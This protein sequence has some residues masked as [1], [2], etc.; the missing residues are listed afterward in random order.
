MIGAMPNLEIL[1]I[2]QHSGNGDSFWTPSVDTN[3][4]QLLSPP[5]LHTL[6]LLDTWTFASP[7]LT[8]LSYLLPWS[9]S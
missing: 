9:L 2:Y 7:Q 5:F 3:I 4:I 1:K 8:T 6:K